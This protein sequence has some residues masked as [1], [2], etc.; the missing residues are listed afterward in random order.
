MGSR[1][2]D[3]RV[4]LAVHAAHVILRASEV[5][6]P[7][8]GDVLRRTLLSGESDEPL[9]IPRTSHGQIG[10][11]A[12]G[13]SQVCESAGIRLLLIEPNDLAS[14]TTLSKKIA[15]VLAR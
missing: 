3:S 11:M 12:C 7:H 6:V 5:T 4:R 2:R 8:H 9:A 1:C 13:K 10:C 14:R 15:K